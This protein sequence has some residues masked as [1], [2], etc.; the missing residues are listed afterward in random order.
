[1]KPIADLIEFGTSDFIE[2]CINHH[3]EVTKEERENLE[4]I[5][6]RAS[7]AVEVLG[8]ALPK[9]GRI[10][11]VAAKCDE[12]GNL[13]EDVVFELGVLIE[14]IG[15]ALESCSSLVDRVS[16]ALEKT[17][18]PQSINPPRVT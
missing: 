16:R 11:W 13:D 4:L 12:G 2:R 10:V 6:N 15:D 7:N 3:S 5:Q 14:E 9:L 17:R 1:M 18:G 8:S